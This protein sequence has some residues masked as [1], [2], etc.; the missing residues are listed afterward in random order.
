MPK[1]EGAAVL[2]TLRTGARARTIATEGQIELVIRGRLAERVRE[3]ARV[4]GAASVE[5]YCEQILEWFV[6]EHRSG[7]ERVDPLRHG[8]RYDDAWEST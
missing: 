6:V 2:G 7:K 5:S 1:A 4:S 3:L 8:N